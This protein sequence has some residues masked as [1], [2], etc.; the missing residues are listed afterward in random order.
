M[1]FDD[2]HPFDIDQVPANW[3]LDDDVVGRIFLAK[4]EGI[5]PP[6]LLST[7]KYAYGCSGIRHYNNRVPAGAPFVGPNNKIMKIRCIAA[8]HMVLVEMRGTWKEYAKV[9]CEPYNNGEL[10]DDFKNAPSY[11]PWMRYMLGLSKSPG[12][13]WL[14]PYNL[15]VARIAD[16]KREKTWPYSR[17][18]FGIS[19]VMSPRNWKDEPLELVFGTRRMEESGNSPMIAIEPH[20]TEEKTFVD[21]EEQR[22][23]PETTSSRELSPQA[24]PLHMS[25]QFTPIN[26][27]PRVLLQQGNH[28]LDEFESSEA[29]APLRTSSVSR[30]GSF[31]EVFNVG[32]AKRK[33]SELTGTQP[34]QP[35]Q[36]VGIPT[37]K[38]KTDNLDWK[39]ELFNNTLSSIKLI[40][41][42]LAKHTICDFKCLAKID[43]TAGQEF[44][45]VIKKSIQDTIDLIDTQAQFAKH[46][47]VHNE[48]GAYARQKCIVGR[49]HDTDD[50]DDDET[51]RELTDEM[52][53]EDDKL[54]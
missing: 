24:P 12:S 51:L 44:L 14:P 42:T 17:Y 2:E 21:T 8:K 36:E 19:N 28:L 20:T 33:A 53:C 48:H 27:P 45:K 7:F 40:N 4:L 16:Q 1:A 6:D 30:R 35:L 15:A 23:C 49:E 3:W 46:A 31:E 25:N 32:F 52:E 26:K 5:V 39:A 18:R 50:F 37:K 54:L 34:A 13:T 47:V 22:A 41:T 11:E 38:T 29:L 10:N 43:A 9:E